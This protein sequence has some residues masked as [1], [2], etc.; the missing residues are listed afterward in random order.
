MYYR[1]GQYK[2]VTVCRMAFRIATF[3]WLGNSLLFGLYFVTSNIKLY[4][5]VCQIMIVTDSSTKR[6]CTV[7]GLVWLTAVNFCLCFFLATRRWWMWL[8][9][10][11]PHITHFL[12]TGSKYSG[13]RPFLHCE[14]MNSLESLIT[15]TIITLDGCMSDINLK[16]SAVCVCEISE[17]ALKRGKKY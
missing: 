8:L 15:L 2:E 11:S 16:L 10:I 14:Q 4:I 9:N 5:Y 17:T 12:E 1:N 6:S 7:Q 3:C 13:I